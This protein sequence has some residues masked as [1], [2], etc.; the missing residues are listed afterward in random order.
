MADME[1]IKLGF[2]S[3]RRSFYMRRWRWS[4]PAGRQG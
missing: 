2:V 1:E 4:L 3:K